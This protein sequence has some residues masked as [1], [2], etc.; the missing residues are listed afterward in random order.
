MGGWNGASNRIN[1]A[2]GDMLASGFDKSKF[3]LASVTSPDNTY[4]NKSLFSNP[5]PLTLGTA[6]RA[7]TQARGFGTINE[8]ISLLKAFLVHEKYRIQLRAEALNAFNRSTLGGI[9]T[10]VT[11]PQFG[12]VTG[13]TGNRQIQF[14]VRLDF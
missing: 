4:L 5:A 2:A 14:T 6:A 10:D 11:N 13:I 8:D 3:N 7:Y 1:I 12:Q 9:V